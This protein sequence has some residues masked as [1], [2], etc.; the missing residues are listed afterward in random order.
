[1]AGYYQSEAELAWAGKCI[2]NSVF[3]VSPSSYSSPACVFSFLLLFRAA[4]QSLGLL[5][6]EKHRMSVEPD[7]YICVR[8]VEEATCKVLLELM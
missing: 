2:C 3:A 1:M 8:G 4:Y 6:G 7:L 5:Q